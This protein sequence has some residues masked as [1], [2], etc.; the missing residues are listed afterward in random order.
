MAFFDFLK[1]FG[2]ARLAA[3]G[4]VT[5]ALVGVF[6]FITIRASQ[7]RMVPLFSDLSLTDA[8]SAVKT[9]E[10]QGIRYQLRGDGSAIFVPAESA[11]A[12]RMKLAETGLPTGGGVGWEIFDKGD[13]LSATSFLQNVNKM[14]A[15]EGELAR[16][17]RALD[18]VAA[19]R[20]HLVVPE[21]Q[22]FARDAIKPSASIVLRVR[23]DLSQGQIR[24][25]RHLTASAVQGL[26]PQRVSIVDEGGR[27]LADGASDNAEGVVAQ[28]HEVAFERRLREQVQGIVERAVGIGRARA[29][30][31]AEFD[32]AR[33]TETADRF[34]PENR[35]VRSTQNREESSETQA[36][37]NAVTASAELPNAR[38]QPA[39]GQQP[40]QA[41][42]NR[43][44][45]T[46]NEETVNYEISRTTRTQ[47]TEGSRLKRLSVAVLVDGV[48][49]GN[50]GGEMTYSPR[51]QEELDRIA[52]LVRSS[53][54]F[55]KERGDQLEVVNLR[56]AEAPG[57]RLTAD[58][59][60]GLPLG[61][62][63]E[64]ILRLAELLVLGII[65]LFVLLFV[66]RPLVRRILTPEARE[67]VAT[68]GEPQVPALP[69][70]DTPA[71]PAAPPGGSRLL[72]MAQ[73]SGSAHAQSLQTVGELA[74]NNPRETVGIIRQWLGEA[75]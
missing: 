53:I 41:A 37:D 49:A 45:T 19:A 58:E 2:A 15:I 20:V 56:F 48:Y 71:L 11:A 72:E 3:M 10:A 1:G 32:R 70:P 24:A 55:D 73:M 9:L 64:D 7:P 28:E 30:V 60:S 50:P 4:A 8:A 18:R 52:A 31:H 61:L 47:V 6:A 42:A 57:I 39:G 51:A 35:V 74:K 13:G 27:L 23:G 22:L 62:E 25:I 34:D 40:A 59:N 44:R 26:E 68:S 17:I 63:R 67:A 36:N 75:A 69:A 29:E 14:R 54:G 21:R 66:M 38:P 46:K 33:V 65:A 43:D 16:S 12:A 5:L